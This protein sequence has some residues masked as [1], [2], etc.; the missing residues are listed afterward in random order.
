MHVAIVTDMIAPLINRFSALE[1]ENENLSSR[2]AE[3][4]S[5]QEFFL[6]Q[7]APADKE[8]KIAL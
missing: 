5:K 6:P 2:I 3:L 4:E 8:D 1:K 7:V